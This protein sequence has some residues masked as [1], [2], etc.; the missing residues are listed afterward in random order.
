MIR[1]S[2]PCGLPGVLI[3]FLQ[4]GFEKPCE[5]NR[6]IVEGRI[7]LPSNGKALKDDY[8]FGDEVI[9]C[10]KPLNPDWGIEV[11]QGLRTVVMRGMGDT[12]GEAFAGVEA[13]VM[14]ALGPLVEA[15]YKRKEILR[16]T[17]WKP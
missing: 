9:L 3:E 7:S 14:E 4:V 16:E 5:G 1:E 17:W 11:T 12:F 2:N 10:G 8:C 15:Y 13:D 6:C